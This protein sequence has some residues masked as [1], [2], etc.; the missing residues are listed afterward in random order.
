MSRRMQTRL[1]LCWI[2][3]Y[4][5]GMA[6]DIATTSSHRLGLDPAP[7]GLCIVQDLVNTAAI[8][9]FAVP[10]LLADPVVAQRWLTPALREWSERA[11]QPQAHLTL[12]RR[13]LTALRRLRAE[14]RHW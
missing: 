3:L 2:G 5:P 14:L 1:W 12:N 13:D 10:D 8:S 4:A 11:G 6:S 7:G 9:A